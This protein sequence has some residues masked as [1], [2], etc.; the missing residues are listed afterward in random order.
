MCLGVPM[1]Q[2]F[3]AR[4]PNP[5][6]VTGHARTYLCATVA[7]CDTELIELKA[8]LVRVSRHP[9]LVDET[10]GDIDKLLEHR[11]KLARREAIAEAMR[12]AREA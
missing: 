10:Y 12:V 1:A 11:T 7:E 9:K 4:A 5:A 2:R 3:T 8:R 6:E